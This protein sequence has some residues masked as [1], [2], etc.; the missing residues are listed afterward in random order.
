M[1]VLVVEPAHTGHRFTYLRHLTPALLELT[2]EVIVATS[3]QAAA[4]TE[5]EINVQ[6]FADLV[7]IDDCGDLSAVRLRDRVTQRCRMLCDAVARFQPDHVYVPTA[8]GVAQSLGLRRMLAHRRPWRNAEAEAA[9]HSAGFAYQQPSW[10]RHLASRV[11]LAAVKNAG[12]T[13]THFVDVNGYEFARKDRRHGSSIRLL[14]DPVEAVERIST[15]EAR[16]RLDLPQDGRYIG[17]FGVMVERKG[18]DLLI[19]AFADARLAKTDRLL[20]VGKHSESILTLLNQ[21]YP[22]LIRSGRI[23]S[24]NRFVEVQQMLDS[25]A[26]MD[27]VCTPFRRSES[28]SSIVIRAAAAGRPVLGSDHG[29]IQSIVPSLGLGWTCNVHDHEAF[30]RAI[31]ARLDEAQ[32]HEPTPTAERF[33]AFNSPA[34]FNAAWVR[35]LRER[36]GLPADAERIEW[37]SVT[38]KKSCD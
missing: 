29:W 22:H 21:N 17:C 23:I 26:A 10:R 5:Y 27:L 19:A 28:I 32:Q 35:R 30:S 3:R 15:A 18:I 14:P 38:E 7:E 9:M 13:V 12:W 31:A 11:S 4:S 20:L 1:R 37:S 6:P 8:D 34:N 2:G 25:F 24:V 16:R 33:V 36:L